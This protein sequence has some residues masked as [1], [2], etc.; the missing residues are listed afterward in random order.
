MRGYAVSAGTGFGS[1]LLGSDDMQH[2]E[3]LRRF[4]YVVS[5]IK[6]EHNPAPQHECLVRVPGFKCP[7]I[8]CKEP[9]WNERP[10]AKKVKKIA[11][12]HVASVTAL[13]RHWN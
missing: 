10:S 4:R 9:K 7:S 5:R 2:G 13:G 6:R 3:M 8:G 1:K 11:T 12:V